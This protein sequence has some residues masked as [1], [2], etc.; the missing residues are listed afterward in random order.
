MLL[1][2][3]VVAG[4]CA[5]DLVR[6]DEPLVCVV[7]MPTLLAPAPDL[8]E[9][10]DEMYLVDDWIS[11]RFGDDRV[12]SPRHFI[13]RCGGE[14]QTF[15]SP[16]GRPQSILYSPFEG[17]PR[18]Y[19]FD[20]ETRRLWLLDRLERPGI[21]I[22][23]DLGIIPGEG[24]VEFWNDGGAFAAITYT[25]DQAKPYA[26]AGIGATAKW[27]WTH[28]G[29]PDH[30]L[31]PL[32]EFVDTPTAGPAWDFWTLD[33]AGELRRRDFAGGTDIVIADHVRAADPVDGSERVIWQA[34]TDG[35]DEPVYL[36]DLSTGT[37]IQLTTNE[38]TPIAWGRDAT[39]SRAT[40][41]WTTTHDGAYLAM[42][43]PDARYVRVYR[44]DTG[45]AL[46]VPPHVG[47]EAYSGDGFWLRLADSDPSL[48]VDAWW[49][50]GRDPIVWRRGEPNEYLSLL[51]GGETIE[52]IE[53]KPVIIDGPEQWFLRSYDPNTGETRLIADVGPR[54]ARIGPDRLLVTRL[55]PWTY[56]RQSLVLLDIALD[57]STMLVEQVGA[58]WRHVDGEGVYYIDRTWPAATGVWVMPIPA[59]DAI[60]AAQRG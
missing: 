50:P 44:G 47:R 34:M 10:E 9:G 56:G 32:G 45:E 1:L 3:A 31:A 53:Y 49:E 52:W 5:D 58:N 26:A 60:P 7:K 37:D 48:Q 51:H 29:D 43:G 57:T 28:D 6:L 54:F 11:L 15:A 2:A 35:V 8:S 27:V 4:A 23:V 12:E 17:D 20:G 24:S 21:D 22:P 18:I 38:F 55:D 33:N 14:L 16:N 19:S 25:L 59:A 30:P 42:I 13:R 41:T 39:V 36:R 40:G 46:A